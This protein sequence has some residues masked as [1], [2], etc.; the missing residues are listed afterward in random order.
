[1]T[2]PHRPPRFSDSRM[3][4]LALLAIALLLVAA[5]LNGV[6]PV[7]VTA[8]AHS[9]SGHYIAAGTLGPEEKIPFQRVDRAIE[10][11]HLDADGRPDEFE[12]YEGVLL[13][14]AEALPMQPGD[15]ALARVSTLLNKSL[16]APAAGDLSTLMPDFLAY[17]RAEHSLLGLAPGGPRSAEEAY[18]HLRIQDAL[19]RT[20]LGED[21]ADR[22]Y[23]TSHQMT[24]THLLRQ[25]L[26]ERD[27]LSEEEKQRLIREQMEALA[28][29]QP[30]GE[31]E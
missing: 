21:T 10:R 15:A 4:G 6:G 28:A 31:G 1:M 13:A 3:P 5:L 23:R 7:G 9:G 17:H 19:R 16:P 18:V 14:L 25:L 30:D 27:D 26:M 29:R 22:L 24:E 20:T 2:S 11:L 8:P 12:A